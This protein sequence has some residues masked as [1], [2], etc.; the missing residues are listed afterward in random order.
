LGYILSIE[1]E[2]LDFFTGI[3]PYFNAYKISN[4]RQENDVLLDVDE[5]VYEVGTQIPLFISYDIKELFSVWGGGNLNAAYTNRTLN[6]FERFRCHPL[7]VCAPPSPSKRSSN[8]FRYSETLFM[9]F[10]LS[11]KSGLSLVNNFR[12]NLSN[13][14]SWVTSLRY[15]F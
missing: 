3:N 1:D 4:A 14:N 9:G 8:S 10:K 7:S 13:V 11:H 2:D 12:S 15:S 5:K 6:E